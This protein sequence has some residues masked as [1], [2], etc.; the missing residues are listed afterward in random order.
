MS[1]ENTPYYASGAE[2]N[3]EPSE[4]LLVSLLVINGWQNIKDNNSNKAIGYQITWKPSPKF[5]INT[6]SFFGEPY[7]VPDTSKQLMRYFNHVYL[8][9]HPIQKISIA[10]LCD[11]GLQQTKVDGSYD[12]NWV[13]PTLLFKVTPSAKWAFCLRGEYYNDSKNIVFTSTPG[14]VPFKTVGASLNFDYTGIDNVVLRVEGKYF[15]SEKD[16]Y[17]TKIGFTNTSAIITSSIAWWF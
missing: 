6:S 16:V 7:N 14:A 4:K 1:A 11:V 5:G 3:Y 15:S 2:L 10:L 8:Y 17:T 13:N 9:F 12:A